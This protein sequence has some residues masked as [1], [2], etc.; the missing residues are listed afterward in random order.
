MASE[1]KTQGSKRRVLILAGA[2][3][4][5]TIGSGFATGQEIMQYYT[6]YGMAFL[7]TVVVFAVLFLYYNFNFARDGA[8]CQFARANDIYKV[9]CGNK[10]GTVLDYYSTAFCYMSFW[11][12]VGG[13]SSTLEQQYGLPHI[14]GGIILAIIAIV[15]VAAGLDKLVDAIGIVGPIIV[16]LVILIAVITLAG[17]AGNLPEGLAALANTPE[18]LV[19]ATADN[20]IKLAASDGVVPGWL[21][22]GFSYAGFVLLWFAS[23]TS[24]LG[25]KNR[26]GDLNKGIVGGTIAVCLAI[27]LVALSQICTINVE[28]IS[29]PGTYVWNADIPNLILAEKILPAFSAVFAIVVF[30]GIY[31][32]AV[33]LL[34]NPVSRFAEEGTTRFRL[35]AIILGV[36]G[37]L[38]GLFL[39]FRVLVNV[40]Y[41]INGYVGAVL[42]I[43]M[44]VKNV[45][46]FIAHRRGV[47]LPSAKQYEELTAEGIAAAADPNM[48]YR[49]G[50]GLGRYAEAASEASERHIDAI[51]NFAEAAASILRSEGPTAVTA[52]SVASAAGAQHEDVVNEYENVDE[53]LREA[54]EANAISW[55]T[56]AEAAAEH[57]ESLSPE[58]ARKCVVDLLLEACL[59]KGDTISVQHYGQLMQAA[60]SDVVVSVYRQMRP[61]TDAAISRIL[62]RAQLDVPPW[63][64]V[65]VVD[66]AAIKGISEGLLVR[67]VAREQLEKVLDQASGHTASTQTSK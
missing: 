3:I 1:A 66:G 57:A 15:T 51:A 19:T 65:S 60:D 38:V 9:Y 5:F 59:P 56:R 12:M 14:V 39:P 22:S 18:G 43:F 46:D 58:E 30:A 16:L 33:P 28:S 62:Y 34:Y 54:A 8:R 27:V 13:A 52:S 6:G 31:T 61:R 44:V 48:I 47:E 50:E 53:L 11:V 21:M 25:M 7:G 37:M 17:N 64:V 32:T 20:N 67:R 24:A 10:L 42:L 45:R 2:I 23:F 49:A 55:V 41:V 29:N 26:L 63:L 4:A 35:L 36:A 40:I